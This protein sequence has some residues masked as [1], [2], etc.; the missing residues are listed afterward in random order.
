MLDGI[1]TLAFVHFIGVIGIYN[2]FLFISVKFSL[3]WMACLQAARPDWA[4]SRPTITA[5]CCI[6][7]IVP[8]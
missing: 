3:S 4:G 6:L 7:L 5:L 8:P 2:V 1:L